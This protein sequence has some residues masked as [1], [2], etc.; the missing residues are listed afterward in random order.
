MGIAVLSLN[1]YLGSYGFALNLNLNLGTYLLAILF[2]IKLANHVFFLLQMGHY[3]MSS[4]A[5]LQSESCTLLASG[6]CNGTVYFSEIGIR[7][8]Q[9]PMVHTKCLPNLDHNPTTNSSIIL[10]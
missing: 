3:T 9:V 1:T 5:V 7:G 2:Y 8:D 6:N 10:G 4:S